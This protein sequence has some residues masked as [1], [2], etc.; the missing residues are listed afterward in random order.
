[1]DDIIILGWSKS[2]L[3]RA[4]K[5]IREII[6]PW[7][8]EVK[9]NWCIRPV[10][11]GIDWVG[12]VTYPDH[13]LLRKRT[14]V[15]M[16]RACRRISRQWDEGRE[17]DEHDLGTLSSYNGCLAWCDG[18]RLGTQ[19]VYP[20]LEEARCRLSQQEARRPCRR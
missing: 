15:R 4:L 6:A 3:R 11:E 1:M 14:K 17:P 10:E 16:K 19:T 5:R 7:G 12:Y 20:L 18:H 13:C 2:W 8:L 9:D